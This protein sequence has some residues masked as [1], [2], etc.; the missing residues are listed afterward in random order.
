MLLIGLLVHDIGML[1]QNPTDLPD[2]ATPLQ[3]KALSSDVATWV[4][5]THVLRLE[6]LLRRVLNGHEHTAF[7]SSPLFQLSL[8]V[9]QSHQQWPWEWTGEWCDTTR[10][11]GIAA[12]VA[13]AD[14]LDEDSARCDTTTLLEHREGNLTNRAHWLRHALT[15][16]RVLVAQGR[17]RVTMVKPPGGTDLLRPLYAAL[18]N[19]F[20]LVGLYETEL[21]HLGA[22]ITNIILDPSTGIPDRESST[23]TEWDK[24]RGFSTERAFCYQL[25]RTFMAPV[26]KDVSRMSPEMIAALR[27]A[28]LED[29]DTTLLTH[30]EGSEEPRSEYERTFS[31]LLGEGI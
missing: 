3:S 9:A 10:T 25:L 21:K 18:R 17:I 26:V 22:A 8:N 16:N 11:R 7:Q 12:V 28:C 27:V 31:A 4:R 30:C 13:V 1:S 24:V 15:D 6:K 23:L 2:E 14:L 19:H 29:V 5:Q 20:R